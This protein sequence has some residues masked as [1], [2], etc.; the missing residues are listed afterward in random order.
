MANGGDESPEAV[1][2]DRRGQPI[3]YETLRRLQAPYEEIEHE[4]AFTVPDMERIPFPG[5]VVIA[6]NLFL[7]DHRGRRHFLI[8]LRK[9]KSADLRALGG[10]I[11]SRLSFASEERLVRHL[12][13]TAGSVTPL[14]VL[15]DAAKAVEVLFDPDLRDG[16]R[17]G[18]HPNVNTATLLLAFDDIVRVVADH[19]NP[20][21]FLT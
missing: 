19:G 10:A 13:V 9:D 4:P 15:N 3:V 16:G 2:R 20:V 17:V 6:K 18:V 14:A 8:V 1:P 5:D 12:G 11:G 21:G 7:R